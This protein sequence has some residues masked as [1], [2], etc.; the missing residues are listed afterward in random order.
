[1]EWYVEKEEVLAYHDTPSLWVFHDSR[2]IHPQLVQIYQ[3]V[4]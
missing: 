3:F 2:Y 4:D 1:M